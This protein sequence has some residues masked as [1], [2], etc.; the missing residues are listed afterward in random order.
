[1]NFTRFLSMFLLLV[2][3]L[4]ASFNAFALEVKD[5]EL[6]LN[7]KSAVLMDVNTGTVL[8][9]YNMDDSLPPASVTKIMTLLLVFEAIDKGDLKIDEKLTV[10]ENA[11]SMGGSQVFLEPGEAMSVEELIKCVA[12]A[13]AN[14]AALTLAE[15]IGGS[16]ESFVLMMN[17]RAEELGMKNT[18]FENVTGLDDTAVNHVASAYDIA[19]MSRELLKHEKI[20][21]FT[22]IWMDTIR[23][24]EFG[25]SNT[26]KL[27]K[28]YKG[29]TG[30]KTGSTS[31]AGFCVSASAKR[32]E[33]HLIAVVMGAETSNERNIAASKLLDYGFA[34][35]AIF[36]DEKAECGEIKVIKGK[37]DKIKVGFKEFFCLENF[38]NVSKIEKEI[39]IN[40]SVTAPI[41]KD[42]AV[43][44]IVYKLNGKIIGET[45]VI[46]L[47]SA[48]KITFFEYFTKV[49][50]NFLL[51]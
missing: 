12:V 50:K 46:T 42:E 27:V 36:K 2:V 34:N 13:S 30:L 21:E 51:N 1:M 20:T 19:L 35:Y 23:G 44:K 48:E 49:L 38:G 10:S 14:D 11:S 29:I 24:G 31:K 25:L 17:K 18:N 4:S 26:N 39:I 3:L 32:G 5:V 43:G 7:V 33:L 37:V 16:E 45:P 41:K 8:Y 40:E 47:E 6:E 15:H 22:T 28:Y 9:S